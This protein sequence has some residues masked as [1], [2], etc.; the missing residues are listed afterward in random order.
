MLNRYALARTLGGLLG[1]GGGYL[2]WEMLRNAMLLE[3]PAGAWEAATA[4]GAFVSLLGI[5]GVALIMTPGLVLSAVAE[6]ATRWM[7]RSSSRRAGVEQQPS[8]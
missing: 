2:L 3:I 5:A 1:L 4:S 6:Q 7:S 8:S